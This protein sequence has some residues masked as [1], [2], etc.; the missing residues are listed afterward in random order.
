[1]PYSP[2][3]VREAREAGYSDKE[4]TN[5]LSSK[6]DMADKINQARLNGESYEDIVD[7]LSGEQKGFV[8]RVKQGATDAYLSVA[9]MGNWLGQK[10]GLGDI[11]IGTDGISYKSPEELA[12]EQGFIEDAIKEN[13]NRIGDPGLAEDFMIAAGNPLNWAAGAMGGSAAVQGLRGGLGYE[14]GTPQEGEFDLGEKVKD[15]GIAGA[16]GAALGPPT[17]KILKGVGDKVTKYAGIIPRTLIKA[18]P[19]AVIP[20]TERGAIPRAQKQISKLVPDRDAALEGME[21]ETIANLTPAQ[22]SGDEGLLS[23]EKTVAE[24]SPEARKHLQQQNDDALVTLQTE[25][26]KIGGGTPAKTTE[27][28]DKRRTDLLTKAEEQAATAT[29]ES[30]TS[31]EKLLPQKRPSEASVQVRE[32]LDTALS[33]ARKTETDLWK[34]VPETDVDIT[35][36]RG[37][38]DEVISTTPK[39]QKDDIPSSLMDSVLGSKK[40]AVLDADGI[41]IGGTTTTESTT[42]LQGLRSKLL[43]EGRIARAAGNYNKARIADDLADAT[44]DAMGATAGDI[45]SESGQAL[46]DALDY[47]RELNEKFRKGSVGKVLGSDRIGGERIAPEMTLERTLSTGKTKGGVAIAELEKAA[48]TDNLKQGVSDYVLN[49]FKFKVIKDD[50]VDPDK[51]RKFIEENADILD[52]FPELKANIE[53]SITKQSTAKFKTERSEGLKKSLFSKQQSKTAEFLDA[54]V[55]KEFERV[56]ASKDP[57]ALMANLRNT[58]AKDETGE[59]LQGLK[60]GAVEYLVKKSG[61]SGKKMDSL[62]NDKRT[63]AALNELL[64]GREKQR[65]NQIIKELGMIEKSGDKLPRVVSDAPNMLM[66]VAARVTGAKIGSAVGGGNAGSSIQS[67]AIGSSTAKKVLGNLTN[68]KAE[69]LLTKAVFDPELMKILLMDVGE[70]TGN[71]KLVEKRLSKWFKNNDDFSSVF[72][73]GEAAKIADESLEEND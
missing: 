23:L 48:S 31:T 73:G 1:M 11:Y 64:N 40:S 20:F 59:A 67:A 22:K 68:D 56:L 27:F 60:T 47:S 4:I 17:E 41:P 7:H 55:G 14:L 44:L 32:E 42:E 13:K 33:N 28:V 37:K 70:K 34:K 38:Y 49:Q 61:L 63:Q 66:S 21:K 25:L 71:T 57:R 3:K 15:T 50:V 69:A 54:P 10:T 35:S 72:L 29:K 46:R 16:F 2:E 43:E 62:F 26:E 58:V 30:L 12:V 24:S 51:A 6:S 52:K 9:Q 8:N 65:L 53:D 45:K 36:L 19:S 18:V 39:A 5:F